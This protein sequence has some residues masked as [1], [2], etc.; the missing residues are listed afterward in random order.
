MRLKFLFLVPLVFLAAC[1]ATPPPKKACPPPPLAKAVMA[2]SRTAENTQRDMYRKPYRTLRFFG[3]KPDM[4]V[5]EIWPGRGWYTEILA[6]Y[7]KDSGTYI[8]AGFN[9]DSHIAYYRKLAAE[10]EQKIFS[11]PELYG[12]AMLTELEPPEHMTIAP[13]ESADMVLTFR[14]VHNWMRNGYTDDVYKA[15]YDALKPGGVLGVVEHRLP[16]DR[17]QDPRALNGYVKESVVIDQA[18][19]AGFKL[20]ARSEHLANPADTA[21]H[22]EGVWSLTPTLRNVPEEDKQKYKAIGESDRMALK[23]VKPAN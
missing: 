1:A 9:K 18:E 13:A 15:M 8:A 5:V 2:D 17:E 21:D 11:Q 6:P 16:E 14:N 23:F 19:N 10:F 20:V 4:N 22:P 12:E 7:L 3:I